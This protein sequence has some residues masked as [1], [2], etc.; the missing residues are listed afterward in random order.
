VKRNFLSLDF[1]W[2]LFTGCVLGLIVDSG[3]VILSV[4]FD[5]LFFVNLITISECVLLAVAI[6]A[7][8]ITPGM[9]N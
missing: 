3:L 9:E 4:V 7:I 8:L 1:K 6:V 5:R 2:Y